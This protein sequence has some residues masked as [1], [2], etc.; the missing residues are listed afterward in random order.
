MRNA[1]KWGLAL[2]VA[3][4]TLVAHA[5]TGMKFISTPGDYIGQ[6]TTQTYSAPAATITSSGATGYVTVSVTE[7]GH[8]WYL[9]FAAPQN[10]PLA[11]GSYPNAAR[12]PFNSPLAGGLSISGDGR[13]CNT[14]KGW[15][16]V[17]EYEL[18]INN[19][20]VK[21][22]I[23]FEQNCEVTMPPLYGSVRVNSN[24]PL[25]VPELQAVAGADFGV[26][27]G[28]SAT[29]DGSQSF[30]RRRPG[31]L[32]YQWTQ[33]NGPPV[34]LSNPNVVKPTFMAPDVPLTGGTLQFRLDVTEGGARKSLD[35]VVV[36]VQ[37]A[38]APR[39][40]VSFHGD[41][42]DYITGGQS[43]EYDTTNAVINF[44]RNS[45]SGVSL[46]VSGSTWW[47][48]DTAPPNGAPF[49]TGTYLNAQRYPFQ[50][51]S[52][53]GLSLSGDGR[54]CNTLTGQFTVYQAQFD[55]SGNPEVLDVSFEQHCEGLPPAAYG[56][57]LLNAVPHAILAPMLRAARKQYGVRD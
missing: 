57:V 39:T 20:V 42:G 56:Q 43:Y 4:Q 50:A 33:L 52:V 29:L 47:Y 17:L 23:D 41:P 11:R 7:G 6:G 15:F 19:N 44:S 46:N 54:G 48:L 51:A 36:L 22:A 53:P 9:D 14:L 40:Q 8:W 21:L 18:D 2:L 26:Y 25:S 28:Q 10:T 13:G 12:Y 24:K 32:T 16:Q 38:N 45:A 49:T 37:S 5:G 3:G 55:S 30:S 35:N 1:C 34:V 31:S 27:S